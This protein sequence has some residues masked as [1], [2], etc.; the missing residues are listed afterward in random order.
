MAD[1]TGMTAQ[2]MLQIA[3]DT[4]VS[5]VVDGDNLVLETRGGDTIDAGHVKGTPGA[6]GGT[7]QAFQDWINDSASG[8]RSALSSLLNPTRR[9]VG[10]K[11]SCVIIGSDQAL[12]RTGGWTEQLCTRLGLTQRNFAHALGRIEGP[13]TF[14]TQIQ[15]A[16]DSATFANDDVALVVIADTSWSI[17]AWRDVNN[18]ITDL[19]PALVT[20]FNLAVSTFPNARVICVP[21]IWPPDPDVHLNGIAGVG[22]QE[23]WSY[24]LAQVV[25]NYIKPACRETKV[26]FVDQSWTWLTGLTGIMGSIE[27]NSRFYPTSTGAQIIA[28][29]VISHLKGTGTR[30]DTG[31]T[32]VEYLSWGEPSLEFGMR[33]M[34]CRREGW[35]VF[36]EGSFKRSAYSSGEAPV[37]LFKFPMGF[38]PARTSEAA[39][40]QV[41]SINT[42]HG[43]IYHD[44]HFRIHQV[45]VPGL[46]FYMSG[47][48][49]LY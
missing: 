5:G 41:D 3:N 11:N 39:A 24:A 7:D 22:Y 32:D 42:H 45:V 35:T 46:I 2:K 31:W 27:A 43:A 23:I 10:L 18:V 25:Y 17:Q 34:K 30:A 20:A 4:V 6:P 37:Y 21:V 15:N 12:Q 19:K 38:R 48:F 1:V 13:N 16:R 26:E 28:D 14:L 36:Y 49:Q 29:W 47:S 44:G 8:T 40:R 33:K 9:V